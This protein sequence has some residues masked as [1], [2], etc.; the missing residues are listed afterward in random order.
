MCYWGVG[1]RSWSSQFYSVSKFGHNVWSPRIKCLII[2]MKVPTIQ[3]P[4]YQPG[5]HIIITHNPLTYDQNE[6]VQFYHMFIHVI[7]T[8]AHDFPTQTHSPNKPTWR[9]TRLV[10]RHNSMDQ[11]TPIYGNHIIPICQTCQFPDTSPY[12]SNNDSK[13]WHIQWRHHCPIHSH[14]FMLIR[15]IQIHFL[16]IHLLLSLKI[17]ASS[18]KTCL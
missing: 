5:D 18:P 1:I 3:C 17:T 15:Q 16:S 9:C 12:L 13:H 14:L 7:W 2:Q 10:Y 6:D 11:I 8:N 4:S